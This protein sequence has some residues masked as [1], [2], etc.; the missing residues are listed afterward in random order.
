MPSE[1]YQ[2]KYVTYS[3]PDANESIMA[4]MTVLVAENTKE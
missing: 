4:E 2:R 3:V 1:K